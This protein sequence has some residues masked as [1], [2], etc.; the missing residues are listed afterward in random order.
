MSDKKPTLEQENAD[1]K[2]RIAVI[3]AALGPKVLGIA[4]EKVMLKFKAT[5]DHECHIL[6]GI[7]FFN[8]DEKEVAIGLSKALCRDHP[9][10]FTQV[11]EAKAA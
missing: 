7:K 2:K 3:E 10:N 1:L 5:P 9:K 4:Q 8:G 11:G 6:S